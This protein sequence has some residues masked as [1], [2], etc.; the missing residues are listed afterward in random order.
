MTALLK[1]H[2]RHLRGVGEYHAEAFLGRICER[3]GEP[4]MAGP[5]D[6]FLSRVSSELPPP[7]GFRAY[8]FHR[9]PAEPIPP[10]SYVLAEPMH[11]LAHGDVVRVAPLRG[12]IHA[13]YRRSSRSNSLLVTERCDNNCLMCSQPPRAEDDRW[14]VDELKEAI[15][16]FAPETTEI[17]ITGGEPGL[18]GPRLLELVECLRIHLPRTAVHILSNGRSFARADF[19]RGLGRLAHP[20]LMVGIPLY[21]DVAEEHDYVVQARGA[22]SEAIRGIL[23]LKR[24][25]VRVEV[26]TVLHAETYARLP[27][28]A[29]FLARNLLFVDHVALMGLELMGFARTNLDR[30]WIDPVDFQRE[31]GDAV[32]I[33]ARAGMDVSIYNLPL[34]VLDPRLRAFARKSISDWKNLYLPACDG[35]AKQSECGGFFASSRLRPS[36]GVRP[37]EATEPRPT[38]D[39]R[40]DT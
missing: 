15:P 18:L 26:R 10:N 4:A 3:A 5:H 20:D 14:I 39:A 7:S 17:G 13:V 29:R 2:G 32:R 34:C 36:R 23:E 31:L 1:L 22:F 35:C 37:F 27:E 33:L 11:H 24:A 40:G 28:L 9:Q 12:A 25:G 30:L 8:F 38:E 6:I 19:A 16:L 21:S